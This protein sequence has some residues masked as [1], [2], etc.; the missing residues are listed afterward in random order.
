[1]FSTIFTLAISASG[2]PVK[3]CVIG[4]LHNKLDRPVF[5]TYSSTADMMH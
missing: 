3:V 5:D 4:E 1:M 2:A